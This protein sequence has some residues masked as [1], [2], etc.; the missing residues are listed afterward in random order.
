M[1]ELRLSLKHNSIMGTMKIQLASAKELQDMATRMKSDISAIEKESGVLIKLLVEAQ[2]QK[3]K[4]G[5]FVYQ[6]ESET[7][8]SKTAVAEYLSKAKELGLD[9][10]NSKDVKEVQAYAAQT[11]EYSD[12]FKSIGNIPNI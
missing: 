7:S 5:T 3:Q 4:L 11:K 2:K 10:S 8:K 6:L 1:H 12:Y 9:G